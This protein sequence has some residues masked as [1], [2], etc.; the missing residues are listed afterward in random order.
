MECI[1]LDGWVS[2][3]HGEIAVEVP[4]GNDF[5]SPHAQP[6]IFLDPDCSNYSR[7]FSKISK[8]LIFN[9]IILG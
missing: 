9:L 5:L 8:S 4:A 2:L 3:D 6:S 1:G 7:V